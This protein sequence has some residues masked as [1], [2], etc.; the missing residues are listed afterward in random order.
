[1]DKIPAIEASLLWLAELATEIAE[2]L[3]DG[4]MQRAEIWGLVPNAF[5]LPKVAAKFKDV[6]GEWIEL[7]KDRSLVDQLI[8]K[9]AQELELNNDKAE[10]TV[11]LTLKV[12]LALG[13]Y[14]E[15][16]IKL[17]K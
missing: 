7:K 17:H 12:G 10:Q 14:I 13:T 11:V 3:E 4:K 8:A 15:D 16:M 2:A 9:V 6:P 1:M 5:R